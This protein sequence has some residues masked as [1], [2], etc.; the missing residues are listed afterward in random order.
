MSK[1]LHVTVAMAMHPQALHILARHAEVTSM[2]WDDARVTA[3]AIGSD[4][5]IT[6]TPRLDA[7]ALDAARKL[8][9]MSGHSCPPELCAE[10]KRRGIAVTAVPELWDTVAD[11]TLALMFAAA[12]NIPQV[13]REIQQGNWRDTHQLKVRY[14][15]R[16]LSGMTAGIVGLGRIGERVAKRLH[17]FDMRL[18]YHDIERKPSA[19]QAFGAQYQLLD[20]LLMQS[21]YIILLAPLTSSTA[22]MIGQREFSIMKQDA[23]LINTGRGALVDEQQLIAALRSGKLAGAGLDVYVEEPLPPDHPL[24]TLDNAVLAPHLGGS[25]Y[26]CDMTLVNDVLRVLNGD[27]PLYPL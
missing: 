9:V 2:A 8:K 11:F 27:A 16:A 17:G 15:G 21:D 25:T 10:A 26:E 1:Q 4:A 13:H 22:G 5:L 20:D 14:S 7:E 18:L 3:S 23:V 24:L 12:R 6:Y 19:E